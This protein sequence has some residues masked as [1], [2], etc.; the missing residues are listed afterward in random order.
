MAKIG[1][2]YGSST[3]N[4]ELVAQKIQDLFGPET[5]TLH[6]VD[7]ATKTDLEKYPYLI[8]GSSTWG[9]GDMQD[10]M[11]DFADVLN[12]AELKDKKIALFGLGDQDTFSDSFVDGMGSLY[13]VLHEKAT[14]IG[15]WPTS[16]YSFIESDAVRN[17]KF[18]GLPIDED[19]QAE[20]TDKRLA[21]WVSELKKEFI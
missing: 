17:K 11:E 3:G 8:I 7:A 18:V 2:F 20:L 4:T 15:Q 1:I 19:N 12:D 10:D 5:A 14:I 21:D 16:G 6:N 13:D 9:I